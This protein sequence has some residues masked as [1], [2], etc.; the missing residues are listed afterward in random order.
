MFRTNNLQLLFFDAKLFPNMCVC[1]CVAVWPQFQHIVHSFLI[2]SISTS[3]DFPTKAMS[4]SAADGKVVPSRYR[5]F[6][7]LHEAQLNA[8]GVPPNLHESLYVKLTTQCFDCFEH[9]GIE[10]DEENNR[11]CNTAHVLLC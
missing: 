10:Q 2:I 1:V 6:L 7:D 5:Q 3:F 11:Q 9:F 4:D 8:L